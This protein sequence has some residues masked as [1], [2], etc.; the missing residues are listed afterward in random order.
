MEVVMSLAGELF[1]FK[2]LLFLLFIERLWNQMVIC[3]RVL[4]L[5]AAA[6]NLGRREGREAEGRKEIM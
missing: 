5:L 1:T 6:A 4:V 2:A 3:D